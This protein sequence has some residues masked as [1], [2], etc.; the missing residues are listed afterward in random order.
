MQAL[1]SV[2]SEMP[3]PIS[4]EFH[5]VVQEMQ[6]GVPMEKALANLLRRIP[7]SDFGFYYHRDQC[8][9]RGRRTVGKYFGYD[10]PHNPGED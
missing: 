1:E 8:P 10:F 6:L 9:A 4:E 5:R 7:S 3:A 2:A